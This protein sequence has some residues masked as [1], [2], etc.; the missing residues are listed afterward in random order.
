[1]T[2]ASTDGKFVVKLKHTGG[3]SCL[4]VFEIIRAI[5]CVLQETQSNKDTS[6]TDIVHT[7][8]K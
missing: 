5:S 4:S 1:M 7:F 8:P 2:R 3:I 6:V